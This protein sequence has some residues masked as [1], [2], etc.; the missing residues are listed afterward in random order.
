MY[1]LEIVGVAAR[2]CPQVVF[3]AGAPAVSAGPGR[4]LP[5]GP[6]WW[7]VVLSYGPLLHAL[8]HWVPGVR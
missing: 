6:R 4:R 5:R 1:A 2:G 8:E 7:S 3:N